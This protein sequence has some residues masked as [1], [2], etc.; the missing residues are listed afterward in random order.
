LGGRRTQFTPEVI[1]RAASMTSKDKRRFPRVQA[2]NVSAHLNVADQSSPCV[3]QNI[4]A[5]GIFIQTPEALPVGMPVAVNLARPGWTKVLRVSGR[6]V[7]AMAERTAA[8]KGTLPGMRIRFDALPK[9]T[10]SDLMVLLKELG[11]PATPLP[12]TV[13]EE[14]EQPPPPAHITQPVSLKE[15]QARVSQLNVPVL[16][17]RTLVPRSRPS[18]SPLPYKGS[19]RAKPMSGSRYQPAGESPPPDAPRLIVQVQGLLMQLG[20]LQSQLEQ[21]DKELH[22][23]R[24]QLKEKEAQLD[25]SDRERKAAELAIQRLAMQLSSRR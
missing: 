1:N 2:K 9:S 15:I 8:K 18:A 10:A 4:S 6:V 14:E 7:W 25:R 5:G 17:D 12:A 22:S 19:S 21:R 11:A 20:D 13:P 24:E 23:M 3:I 16:D